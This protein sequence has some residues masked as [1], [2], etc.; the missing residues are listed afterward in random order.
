MAVEYRIYPP[1]GI[2]RMGNATQEFL[3]ARERLGRRE[4][5]IGAGGVEV[6]ASD[7]KV[8][9]S[10]I[11][12]VGARFRVFAFPDDG[13]PPSV[14]D[15]STG[16]QIQWTVEVANRKNGVVRGGS[17]PANANLPTNS[18]TGAAQRVEPG[19]IGIA[20]A[21]SGP[22]G[23]DGGTFQGVPVSLGELRT[24]T[25]GN[26]IV[27]GSRSNSAS[28]SGASL[29]SFY[30]NANWFDTSCDGS[31]RARVTLANGDVIT[32]VA[33]AWVVCGPPDFAP[34]IEGVVTLYDILRDVQRAHFGVTL[35]VPSFTKDIY[36]ILRRA[37]GLRW[38]SSDPS[39][40]AILTDWATLA[41]TSAS[42][43]P[44]RQATRDQI[45]TGIMSLQQV[46]LTTLQSGLLQQYASGT[47]INDWVGEPVS[48]GITPEE[49]TRTALDCAV[50]PGFYPGIE[51]GII[52]QNP[53]IYATPFDFRIN[54]AVVMPGD[55]TALM[56]V[57]WQADFW[58]CSYGWW[59]SQRPNDVLQGVSGPAHDWADGVFSYLDM[60]DKYARL[61]FVVPQLDSAGNTVFV[62][63]QRDPAL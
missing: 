10:H 33:P 44:L 13:T 27:I 1:I 21:S 31:V 34:D 37:A 24:D 60:V 46:S 26:V 48:A 47:F 17:P 39:W 4:L 19:P 7:Y 22:V 52:S 2:G 30:S 49:L 41:N 3:I 58:A 12:P 14:V 40:S 6:E 42:A 8:D 62:E 38:V 23:L 56:A 57:P 63:R 28:P 5:E 51:M 36:P 35:P 59:P 15:A 29:N 18:P 53:A 61:G 32:N 11:K 16:A 20:G 55:L 9:V 54:T 43:A 25:A 45:I 50:G